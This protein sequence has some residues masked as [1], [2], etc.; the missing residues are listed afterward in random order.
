MTIPAFPQSRPIELGDK[1]VFDA[2]FKRHPPR[3][4]EY[5]FTNLFAWRDAYRFRVSSLDDC[6]LVISQKSGSALDPIGPL[7]AK[8]RVIE[9]AFSLDRS[10]RFIRLPEE[11]AGFFEQG[12]GWSIEED[13]DNF[14]YVYRAFDLIELKGQDFDGKRNFI[15]R[16]NESCSF[17]YQKINPENVAACLS[18][19]EEWCLAKDC[20]R[21][22]GLSAERQAMEEILKNF[23]AL[24]VHGGMITVAG[25]VEAVSLGE[26]LDPETFVVHVEKANGRFL[27]IYQAINQLFCSSE[28]KGFTY[29]NREQDLGVSGLRQA[30]ESYHPHHMVKKYTLEVGKAL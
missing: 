27:G 26:A 13:R 14:D 17:E 10:L 15:K 16:F 11:T 25:K 12:K 19:E 18:F 29:V 9:K 28:A 24:G 6:L 7:E 8:K 1:S 4:S 5:T 3:I 22:E 21:T 23:G 20:Q 2:L 30:K